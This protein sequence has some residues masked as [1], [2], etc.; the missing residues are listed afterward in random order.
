MRDI[1]NAHVGLIKRSAELKE[2][3]LRCYDPALTMA[4]N[5]KNSGVSSAAYYGWIKKD[6]IFRERV[7]ER[8]Q[9]LI[10]ERVKAIEAVSTSAATGEIVTEKVVYDS[11]GN[12]K[13]RQ[14]TQQP[15]SY[16]H[17]EMLL[18]A[19]ASAIYGRNDQGSGGAITINLNIT[20]GSGSVIDSEAV[21]ITNIGKLERQALQGQ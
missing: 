2:T 20:G 4:A 6:E 17:A 21:D 1:S 14:T 7:E 5:W 3:F 15:P 16:K 19:H 11:V 13:E 18:K 12:V 8:K 10:E 9:E